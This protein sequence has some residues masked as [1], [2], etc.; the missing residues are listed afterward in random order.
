MYHLTTRNR[1]VAMMALF[2]ATV[3][4]MTGCG[5]GGSSNPT[6]P[7]TPTPPYVDPNA[8]YVPV[9]SI[10]AGQLASFTFT[11]NRSDLTLSTPTGTE[12]YGVV[13][14]SNSTSNTTYSVTGNGGG[15]NLG[16][17][18]ASELA[19]EG[20]AAG[21]MPNQALADAALRRAA[22]QATPLDRASVRKS[23]RKAVENVGDTLT[24][25]VYSQNTMGWGQTYSQRQAVLRKISTYAKIFVDPNSS[26]NGLSAVSGVDAITQQEIDNFANKFDTVIYPLITQGYGNTFDKDGDGHVT[27]FF[28]P[29]YNQL[30]FAGLFDSVHLYSRNAP[31]IL[32]SAY[33][34]ERDMFVIMCPDTNGV[35]GSHWDHTRWFSAAAET[36]AHEFQHLANHATRKIE[37]SWPE[38]VEWLDEGLSMEAELRYRVAIGDPAAEDRFDS[39]AANPSNYSLT[40]FAWNLGNYGCVGMFM[41]YLYE[42][43]GATALRAL[44]QNPET[45]TANVDAR[46]ASRGGFLGMFNDWSVAVFVEGNKSTINTSLI[47]AKYKYAA[48]MGISLTSQT[49]QIPYGQGF[50]GSMKGMSQ[51]FVRQ[52]PGSTGWSQSSANLTMTDATGGSMRCSIIRVK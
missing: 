12:E 28:S 40:N 45:G 9:G 11:G 46:F 23:V 39:W 44:V 19:A 8:N 21:R 41:H 14:T 36:I 29:L 18:R 42:Q 17:V 5:G 1:T 7:T 49:G 4:A 31:G 3:L 26:A 27:I 43:G 15:T 16:S 6:G 48:D 51:K 25:S 13:I 30:G 50:T 47:D 2:F 22:R 52:V 34:N 32:N 20:R 10:Q 33:S 35:E 38:E 37:H 24:F